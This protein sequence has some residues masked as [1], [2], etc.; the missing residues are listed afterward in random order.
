MA[1]VAFLI[2]WTPHALR[3]I[4]VLS[5]QRKCLEHTA[6]PDR[7][8]FDTR[9]TSLPQLTRSDP[10]F[11]AIPLRSGEI[12]AMGWSP[13]YWR[14]FY[15]RISSGGALGSLGTAFLH[16]LTSRGG[17]VRLV[18]AMVDEDYGRLELSYIVIKP[19]T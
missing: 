8:V 4:Q 2:A 18:A 10:D 17:N 13:S 14:E 7:I 6:P 16:R 1:I 3:R 9:Q 5:L 11:I 12:T 19:G 15:T